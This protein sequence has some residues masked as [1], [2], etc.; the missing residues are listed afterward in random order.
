MAPPGIEPG[1]YPRQGYVLSHWTIG[2]LK[3]TVFDPSS[4]FFSLPPREVCIKV[5]NLEIF[6]YNGFVFLSWHEV[7]IS[8]FYF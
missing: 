3:P 1:S 2:P 4:N 6:K 7:V 8:W 5:N